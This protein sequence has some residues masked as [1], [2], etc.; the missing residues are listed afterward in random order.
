MSDLKLIEAVKA[1]NFQAVSEMIDSG[2]DVNQQDE[3][4]WTSLNWA[5]GKGDT[6]I[7]RSLL[8]HGAD[9]LKLGRD[10]RT[11]YLIALAAGQ[12]EAARLLREAEARTGLAEGSRPERP[13]CKAIVLKQA[14][15]Y[16]AWA[17]SRINWKESQDEDKP[18]SSSETLSEDEIVFLHRDLTVT[19]SM[20][21]GENVI[22]DRV[23]P[24]WEKYC[25]DTLKFDPPD[26][27]DL[28][29]LARAASVNS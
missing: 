5:A 17:E 19:Q 8:E 1:G 10:E 12:A 29:A 3:H 4:G 6:A 26:D 7:V 11:P 16:P 15:Q 9:P 14:R 18:G 13:Y 20:W 23:T 2:A 21:P 24:E 28:L 27:L 25:C 22:F